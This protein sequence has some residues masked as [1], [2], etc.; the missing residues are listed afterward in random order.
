MSDQLPVKPDW[1]LLQQG[2]TVR[3]TAET[4]ALG[5]DAKTSSA[6]RSEMLLPWIQSSINDADKLRGADG[7]DLLFSSKPQERQDAGRNLAEAAKIYQD[8][9][10]KAAKVREALAVRDQALAELPLFTRWRGW[11]ALQN[12][13]ENLKALWTDTYK[14]RDL[15]ENPKIALPD[16]AAAKKAVEDGL[17]SQHEEFDAECS[18]KRDAPSQTPWRE[19][20]E[21]LSVPLTPSAQRMDLIAAQRNISQKLNEG[22]AGADPAKD[23]KA[24]PSAE[25]AKKLGLQQ[26]RLAAAALGETVENGGIV[27]K[28]MHDLRESNW[29]DDLNDVGAVL[30]D[31]LRER[32]KTAADAA[33]DGRSL[34]L[35]DVAGR[36]HQAALTGRLLDAGEALAFLAN[37]DPV[38]EDRDVRLHDLLVWQAERSRLDYWV[39]G[40]PANPTLYYKGAALAYLT[41]AENLAKEGVDD[42]KALPG[43]TKTV[44][45]KK[46]QFDAPGAVAIQFQDNDGNW[47]TTGQTA[48]TDE[49]Q[50]S[51]QYKVAGDKD[52]PAGRPVVWAGSAAK[53]N[54]KALLDV[55]EPGDAGS[56][57]ALAQAAGETSERYT[58]RP[59]PGQDPNPNA[60]RPY[61]E[62]A[63]FQV[64]SLFRGRF[65]TA[66]TT[67]NVYNRPDVVSWQPKEALD[68][69]IAVQAEPEVFQEFAAHN[70]EMV[71]VL[72]YSGS[73]GHDPKD[74]SIK[75]KPPNRRLDKAL[76]ALKICLKQLPPGVRLT[77]LSFNTQGEGASIRSNIKVQFGPKPWQR[78]A[79]DGLIDRL[80]DL[81]PDGA[82]PLVEAVDMAAQQFKT[83]VEAAKAKTILVLTDGGD[84]MFLDG[85]A[86]NT[87]KKAMEE[88]LGKR[89]NKDSGIQVHV[90]GIE[91]QYLPKEEADGAEAFRKA[92]ES[93]VIGGTFIT[94][95]HVERLAADIQQYFLK[96]H[97]WVED[98]K[99][100][101]VTTIQASAQS[102][103]T[104]KSYKN[105]PTIADEGLDISVAPENLR[106]LRVQPKDD[107]YVVVQNHR[108]I[109]GDVTWT[110]FVDQKVHVE[111]GEV[112]VL[113]LVK[114]DANHPFVL[115]RDVYADSPRFS[116][117]RQTLAQSPKKAGP[118]SPWPWLLTVVGDTPNRDRREI[119]AALER[120][121]DVVKAG[122]TLRLKRPDWAWFNVAQPD[123]AKPT[124]GLRFSPRPYYSS[125]FYN[126]DLA[127]WRQSDRPVVESWWWDQDSLGVL[128]EVRRWEKGQAPDQFHNDPSE[129][130]GWGRDRTLKLRDDEPGDKRVVVESV[131]S[132][133]CLV[134]TTPDGRPEIK[135]C[136]VVRLVFPKDEPCFVLP[137]PFLCE[138]GYEQR[139]Y[140]E[141]HRYTGVFYDVD[142]QAVSYLSL[143]SVEQ[144]KSR[145]AVNGRHAQPLTINDITQL[146]PEPLSRD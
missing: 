21:V 102:S 64:D 95:D 23:E 28:K 36:L 51:L 129:L 58:V 89:I 120:T 117:L 114:G 93:D 47:V 121:D 56:P 26:G 17:K 145:A 133:N 16:L 94:E 63:D 140:M 30:R 115:Q 110:K 105:D 82:T 12:K 127:E 130:A 9:A 88:F 15:L 19:L 45:A 69:F 119:T 74:Y 99:S 143:H 92:I 3:R 65:L 25:E 103:P 146:T 57:S 1:A 62:T 113:N 43:R 104:D 11:E 135:K 6:P 61:M 32:A 10:V 71:V 20:E 134:Q 96:L 136:M 53:P 70:S 41:D 78:G 97:Y 8:A 100:E 132:E 101:L 38:N 81:D 34:P 139:F 108:H 42:P 106:L 122:E 137:P 7:E 116:R 31:R 79:E 98:G 4:A 5:M 76:A 131:T 22:T 54:Q 90:V 141:A 77:V 125:P 123:N 49:P 2:L 60:N 33:T 80:G 107:Y 67:V 46:Q 144:I 55:A 109:Q 85:Q 18:K 87:R 37:L 138:K 118:D 124:S 39:T 86:V 52:L 72:D 84:D 142:P 111:P 59:H 29:Q 68:G 112:L 66:K 83:G 50:F 126:L 14:L 27:A 128:P 24:P 44:L 91:F 40:D 35:A 73:M 13:E 75:L 48:V